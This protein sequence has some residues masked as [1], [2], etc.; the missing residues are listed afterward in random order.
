M[1]TQVVSIDRGPNWGGAFQ[2]LAQ[3]LL[4]IYQ[5]QEQ[6]KL[7]QQERQQGLADL[8]N[9]RAYEQRLWDQRHPMTTMPSQYTPPPSGQQGPAAENPQFQP[10]MSAFPA[11]SQMPQEDFGR[12]AFDWATRKQPEPGSWLQLDTGQLV[13]LSNPGLLTDGRNRAVPVNMAGPD[14]GSVWRQVVDPMNQGG[15]GGAATDAQIRAWYN[16]MVKALI[17]PEEIQAR[18]PGYEAAF[19]EN[20]IPIAQSRLAERTWPTVEDARAAEAAI[21]LSQFPANLNPTGMRRFQDPGMP[22]VWI[23]PTT[24]EYVPG[25][26]KKTG[27]F[28]TGRDTISPSAM[29]LMGLTGN[30]ASRGNQPGKSDEEILTLPLKWVQQGVISPKDLADFA[31]EQGMDLATVEYLIRVAMQQGA[32]TP[33]PDDESGV[34]DVFGTTK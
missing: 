4:G 34:N 30:A 27:F 24:Q 7:R 20:L 10:W 32:N 23:D 28:H 8:A 31:K 19:R 21:N 13:P 18:G 1:S 6:E 12:Y 33:S 26:I 3:G 11:G 25:D 14:G 29:P 16:E 22:A 2:S 15:G 9:Q 5:Q 17:T